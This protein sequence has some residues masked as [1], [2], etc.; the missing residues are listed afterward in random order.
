V[1]NFFEN[2]SKFFKCFLLLLIVGAFSVNTFSQ[3]I[4]FSEK[5]KE[6]IKNHPVI[7]HGYEPNWPPYEI[8]ENGRY[9]GIVGDYVKILEREIGIAIE[10]IPNITWEKTITGLKSGEVDFTVCAGI[11]DERKEFL[12]FTEPY[13]SSP[14]VIVTRVD[15]D[16]VGNLRHLVGKTISLPKRYYTG[17]MIRQDYPGIKID[18]KPNIE[19]AIRA[20]SI[21]ETEA[22]VGNLVVVSYYIE[23]KGYSNLKIAAPTDY[24]KAHIALAARKDWPELIS[25]SQKVFDHISYQERDAILQKWI[26][27]RFE[28]GVNMKEIWRYVAIAGFLI[29]MAFIIILFWN[30]SLKREVAKRILIEQALEVAL[31]I[32]NKKSEERKV[33]LQEIHHRVKNNLQIIVSLLRLQKDESEVLLGEK[34]NETITRINTIAL[35]HEK[36]YHSDDLSKIDLKQYITELASDIGNSFTSTNV[37]RLTAESNIDE[38]DL[39]ALIPLALILN[40]LI[41]NSLKYGIEGIHNGEIKISVESRDGIVCMNY[42]DNG[43]W[44]KPIAGVKGFGHTLIEVLTEQL[45]GS[46]EIETENKTSYNFRFKGFSIEPDR[47]QYK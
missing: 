20:V 9:S 21:G 22:F 14:M 6:W 29:F 44:V 28:Y 34:L 25:I 7:Y 43:K 30:K 23:H 32:S 39:K 41:T 19:E 8:F 37:P 2:I 4:E 46:F 10:P 35:V 26:K 3:K 40:E 24:N 31:D 47:L 45:E 42:S 13:I 18:F 36:I 17:E 12:N 16:Y 1:L 11:T 5:E 27:V 15:G 33:L 38:V